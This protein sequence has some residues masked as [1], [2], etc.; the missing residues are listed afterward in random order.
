[1]RAL[2]VD[3]SAALAL[4]RDEPGGSHVESLIRRREGALV[5][6][7]F[8]LEVINSLARRHRWAGTQI[9][10]T[11]FDLEQLG[12]ETRGQDRPTL[13]AVVDLV[14]AH[15]LSAYDAAYLAL[16]L[17]ADA[18]LLTADSELAAAAG[19]RAILVGP[20]SHPDR[21]AEARARY[22]AA[23]RMPDWPRWPGAVA[24]IETLRREAL[25]ALDRE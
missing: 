25:A 11:V 9:L 7:Y 1:M 12:L 10:E 23:R 6:W 15:R 4:V 19:E 24:Y 14:D 13:L 17:E 21:V 8:W 16:A 22:D 20:G 3:A 5:P 18:D 2:V